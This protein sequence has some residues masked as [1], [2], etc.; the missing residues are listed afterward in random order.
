MKQT[1]LWKDKSDGLQTGYP[2]TSTRDLITLR[3]RKDVKFRIQDCRYQI[4]SFL[5]RNVRRRY[6][7]AQQMFF[8][9]ILEDLI[10]FSSSRQVCM[11]DELVD[12]CIFVSFSGRGLIALDR[13]LWLSKTRWIKFNSKKINILAWKVNHNALPTRWNLSNRGS[14]DAIYEGDYK[15]VEPPHSVLLDWTSY[16]EWPGMV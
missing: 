13:S 1:L 11:D 3:P 10:L 16:E 8:D 6:K 4:W 2:K 5:S 14:P 9:H 7:A 12:R 15:M